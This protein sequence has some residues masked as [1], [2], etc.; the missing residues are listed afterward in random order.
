MRIFAFLF[1]S[2][3]FFGSIKVYSQALLPFSLNF[4]KS[5][6]HGDNQIWSISQ[7]SDYAISFATNKQKLDGSFRVNRAIK[8]C[9]S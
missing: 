6:Y 9:F 4:S 8:Y 7:G 3:F 5:D 2:I 1:I